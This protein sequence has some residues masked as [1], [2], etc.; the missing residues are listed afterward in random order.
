LLIPTNKEAREEVDYHLDL[1]RFSFGDVYRGGLKF[2]LNPQE[3]KM[4]AQRQ[5]EWGLRE[6]DFVVGMH[7]GGRGQKRW[8]IERFAKLAQR[9]IRDH[10]AKVVLFWGPGE[11]HV[12]RQFESRPSKGLIIA[13]QLKVRELAGQLERCVVF[14]SCDTGPMHLA[15]AVGTPTVAIFQVPNF[16]RYG[17][18]GSRNR[19]VYR[20]QGDVSVDDVL[21]AFADLCS[22]LS[23]EAADR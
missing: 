4:A 18:E 13:P 2:H 1:L 12:I 10:D 11:R 9:L 22:T 19:I 15:L 21:A 16:D 17:Q 14:I 8:P 23:E 20:P 7:V 6:K 3:R 5:R